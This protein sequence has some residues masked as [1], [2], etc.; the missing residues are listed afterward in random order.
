MNSFNKLCFAILISFI[1]LGKIA[2]SSDPL[3]VY[4]EEYLE[5]EAE[6]YHLAVIGLIDAKSD[7]PYEGAEIANYKLFPGD[8]WKDV[9]EEPSLSYVV[10]I[11]QARLTPTY[12]NKYDEN[13]GGL[14]FD[15]NLDDLIGFDTL[16]FMQLPILP[17]IPFYQSEYNNLNAL[18]PNRVLF[19]EQII[20]PDME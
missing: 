14:V 12:A 18:Y 2:Y 7:S 19:A 8:S 16:I 4:E 1:T 11:D 3:A 9:Y 13:L 17:T 20:Q 10:R 5:E 6:D 15:S